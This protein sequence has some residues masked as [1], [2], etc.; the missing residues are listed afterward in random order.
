FDE[1][2]GEIREVGDRKF[3]AFRG[4]AS[5]SAKQAFLGHANNVEGVTTYVE[6]KG[7]VEPYLSHLRQC[8]QSGIATAGFKHLVDFI[9]NATFQRVTPSGYRDGLPMTLR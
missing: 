1:C 6:S 7:P 2:P 3:R 8:I 5:Q 4:M 9:G